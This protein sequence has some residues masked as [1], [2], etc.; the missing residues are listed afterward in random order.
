M[1][2]QDLELP[3]DLLGHRRESL[4][5]ADRERGCR[6]QAEPQGTAH[7]VSCLPGKGGHPGVMSPLQ[8]PWGTKVQAAMQAAEAFLREGLLCDQQ[9]ALLWQENTAF[10]SHF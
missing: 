4:H 1:L 2:Q 3:Q 5:P 8:E 7:P 9:A 6:A 10:M